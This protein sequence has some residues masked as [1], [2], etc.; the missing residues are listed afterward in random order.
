[1]KKSLLI[2]ALLLSAGAFAQTLVSTSPQN[3]KVVLEEF[4]GINCVF[5]PDG[6]TIAQAIKDQNPD[7]VILV[8][9][10]TGGFANPGSGQPDFRTAFGNALANQS[11]LTGYPS[12]TVNRHVFTGSNTALGRGQWTAAANQILQQSSYVNIAGT[13]DIDV[14]TNELIVN[15]EVYYTG[16]SPES[17]NKL[18]V[19][20]LQDN[21]LGPQTGGNMGNNYVHMHRLVHF[22]TGQ[23]GEDVTSTSE[24]DFSEFTF[25][26]ELPNDYRG[27]EVV[28]ENLKVAAYIAEGN[29]E[30][31]TGANIQPN[32]INV[33]GNDIAIQKI[34]EIPST[35]MSRV[36]P[37][38]EIQNRG[39][40]ALTSID[41]SYSVNDSDTEVYTWTG[42][43]NTFESATIQLDEIIF[44]PDDQVNTIEV[45]IPNDDNNDNNT[46][47]STFSAQSTEGSI[48]STLQIL[49]FTSGP[50]VSWEIKNNSGDVLYNGG[51]YPA[52]STHSIDLDLIDG[53]YEINIIETSGA[54]SVMFNITD[55]NGVALFRSGTSYGGNA[56]GNFSTNS[57]LDINDI[58]Q[59][60]IALYPNPTNGMVNIENAEGFQVE[61]YNLLGKVIL[62]KANISQQETIDLSNLTSGVYYVKLQNEKTTEIKKVVVK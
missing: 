46:K 56:K 37:Q 34:Q 17:T 5:C 7:D 54:G 42:N 58:T 15:L 2:G 8:N 13:A 31:L 14:M 23:W 57:L 18:N 44:T 52:N 6:H 38:I 48:N 51:P 45:S 33:P 19:A 28:L 60:I 40:D 41:I 20:L 21:T 39:G 3:K 59:E 55:E 43:L 1:M 62:R 16:D 10:H 25:T 49:A 35:C 27:I 47:T 30:I 9:V 11:G 22:L 12:G 50:T 53:C 24:G 4:T 29:Q 61:I 36:S 32:F 26:Y